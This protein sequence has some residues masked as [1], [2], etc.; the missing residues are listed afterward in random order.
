MAEKTVDMMIDGKK[1]TV[2]ET[3][4]KSMA[5]KEK[6]VE[7]EINGKIVRVSEHMVPDLM[8]F[9]ATQ[10]KRSI[11]DPPKEL[12]NM[13]PPKKVI[14]PSDKLEDKKEEIPGADVVPK[15]V[16]PAPDLKPKRNVR[17]KV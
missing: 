6:K 8:R 1:V 17:N 7:M 9:G 12:L 10:T 2:S 5:T 16:I 15:K 13:P 11:K 14:L 4:L 3:R